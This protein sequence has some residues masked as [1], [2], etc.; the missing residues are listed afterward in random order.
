MDTQ[1]INSRRNLSAPDPKQ[2]TLSP[3]SAKEHS[4]S[5]TED[6]VS[7]SQDAKSLVQRD[8]VSS[9]KTTSTDVEQRKLSVTDNNDIVLEVID[10]QTQKV[11]RTVPSE[12]QIELRNAISEELDKI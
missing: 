12:E 7:F 2:V 6:I 8:K 9:R 1:A 5:S 3:Q 11:V 4:S 10:A